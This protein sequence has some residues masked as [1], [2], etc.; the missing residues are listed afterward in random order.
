MPKSIYPVL[1]VVLMVALIVGV[2]V[3]F[4]R[5]QSWLRLVAN[6]GIVLVFLVFYLSVLRNR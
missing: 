6:M 4:L 1:Y 5:N 3:L 2:D